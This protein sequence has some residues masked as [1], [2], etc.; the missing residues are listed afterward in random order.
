MLCG[1]GQTQGEEEPPTC[2]C[3]REPSPAP[4]GTLPRWASEGGEGRMSKGRPVAVL[5][6]AI[7]TGLVA[8]FLPENRVPFQGMMGS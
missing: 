6:P 2:G 3:R 5:W 7:L 1:V 8:P 4:C